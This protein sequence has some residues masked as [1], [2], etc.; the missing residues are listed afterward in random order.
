MIDT[1]NGVTTM[2]PLPKTPNPTF[3]EKLKQ[4]IPTKVIMERCPPLMKPKVDYAKRFSKE[5]LLLLS[6]LQSLCGF[7][8]VTTEIVF[9][10]RE[11]RH[12]YATGIWCGFLYGLSGFIGVFASLRPSKSTIVS[13]M[14]MSIVAS[15][16]CIPG[17]V[18]PST[19]MWPHLRSN[20]KDD[21]PAIGH[22]M[23]VMQLVI[24]PVQAVV[25]IASSLMTCK[26][27]CGCCRPRR[28][29]RSVNYTV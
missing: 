18:F 15:L 2:R 23:L 24:T 19:F 9:L 26:A 10:T 29:D 27:I 20:A 16:F 17:L 7:L 14:V 25:A 13:F 5:Y 21:A 3:Q 6:C 8:A 22:A 28:E 12:L 11:R 1:N 4:L